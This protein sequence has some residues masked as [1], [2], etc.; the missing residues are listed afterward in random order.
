LC[1]AGSR[2]VR[3]WTPATLESTE[4]RLH[5]H[6]SSARTFGRVAPS[7][8]KRASRRMAG[9]HECPIGSSVRYSPGGQISGKLRE[10]EYQPGQKTRRRTD[11]LSRTAVYLFLGEAQ[12]VAFARSTRPCPLRSLFDSPLT[13]DFLPSGSNFTTTPHHPHTYN[14]LHH[15]FCVCLVY[16]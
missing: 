13:F 9:R 8:S 2:A 3:T 16:I 4:S 5:L 10:A 11:F 15:C 14:P 12:R 6:P 7:R 1:R